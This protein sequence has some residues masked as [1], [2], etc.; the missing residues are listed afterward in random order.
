MVARAKE[1][2]TALER[3][4]PGG[5]KRRE[6]FSR[7]VGLPGLAAK[8]QSREEPTDGHPVLTALSSLNVNELSPLDALTLL[9]K[10][11]AMAGNS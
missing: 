8:A 3:H 9:H 6:V 2:L 7:Q 11:K 10:W 4:A 1:V 5:G